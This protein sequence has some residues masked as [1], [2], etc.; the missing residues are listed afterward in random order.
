MDQTWSDFLLK[1]VPVVAVLGYF[2]YWLTSYFIKVVNSK[3][4]R[5][6]HKDVEIKELN[7]KLL[8]VT[9]RYLQ[10]TEKNNDLLIEVKGLLNKII[11]K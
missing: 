2:C 11:N 8:E 6:L 1:Q 5:L 4:E 10:S 9:G 7:N 3:D